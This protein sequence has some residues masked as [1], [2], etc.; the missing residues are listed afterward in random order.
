MRRLFLQ[1][2]VAIV[3]ILILFGLLSAMGFLLL[4]PALQNMSW[5]DGVGA[6]VG[7]VLP[8]PERPKEELQAALERF[9]KH[10]PADINIRGADG[11]LLAKVGQEL[12][13]PRPGRSWS[14]WSHAQR[15]GPTVLF[16]LP[17]GRWLV[18]RHSR[19][20]WWHAFGSLVLLAGLAVAVAIGAYPLARRLTRRLE[21]LQRRVD[22]LGAGELSARVEVEGNDEVASLARSFNK[23]ADQIERLVKSQQSIL[24]SASHELRTPL[25]RLSVALELLASEDRPELRE[26]ATKDIAELDELIGELLLAS[27]LDAIERLESQE[28]IDLLALLAEEAAHTD[29]SVSGEPVFVKGN[30]RLLRRLIRNL[31]DN[32]Q[33][34][35]GGSA[36]EA[37]VTPT[38][39][40]S[41]ILRVS[42]RG[43]GVP[44]E[45][46]ERIFEPFYRPPG[47]VKSSDKGVGLGLALVRQIAKH[48][49]GSARCVPRDGGGTCFE[50]QL[51]Q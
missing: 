46:R 29:A 14:G 13:A 21:R 42:D 51:G 17:D 39:P 26:R 45:E 15:G 31:L 6:L 50:V 38:D 1:I 25:A 40:S 22:E 16:R 4:A 36:V 20:P 34:Y 37:S 27:R 3:G 2:Y 5:F 11:E 8:G 35:A 7:D 9:G 49:R 33:R 44:V 47:I 10:L 30:P 32:A 41:A 12:P 18:V 28:D 43:P 19:Q 24:A 48:H 23:A